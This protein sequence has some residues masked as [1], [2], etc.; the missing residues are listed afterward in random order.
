MLTESS[1]PACGR[2]AG[3]DCS[4]V[5]ADVSNIYMYVAF[6]PLLFVRFAKAVMLLMLLSLFGI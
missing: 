5:R 2:E 6:V 1:R 3:D 4:K